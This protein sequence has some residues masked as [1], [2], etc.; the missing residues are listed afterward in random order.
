MSNPLINKIYG[1]SCEQ[2]VPC[3]V[4]VCVGKVI[5][6]CG[7]RRRRPLS[8]F[9]ARTNIGGTKEESPVEMGVGRAGSKAL[10]CSVLLYSS[11]AAVACPVGA[12]SAN[13]AHGGR[14]FNINT[15]AVENGNS[16]IYIYIST[17]TAARKIKSLFGTCSGTA[18]SAYICPSRVCTHFKLQHHS[19][20][21]TIRRTCNFNTGRVV[22]RSGC[23]KV[24]LC[25]MSQ[26]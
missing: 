9:A 13:M 10:F 19:A 14:R 3:R 17:S 16:N 26:A 15:Q 6:G 23:E 8:R 21:D 12:D 1:V 7:P 22:K 4:E 5:D 24:G 18:V 20:A 2:S 25:L 11:L